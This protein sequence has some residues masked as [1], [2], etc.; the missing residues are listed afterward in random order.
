M[1]KGIWDWQLVTVILTV[2]SL[3]FGGFILLEG[4]T[5]EG[6]RLIIRWS[7]RFSVCCF[8]LAFGGGAMH[9]RIQNSFSFWIFRNRKFFGISF[10]LLHLSHLVALFV[11]Q[12]AFHPIFQIAATINLLVGFGAYCFLI[13]MLLTSFDRFKK[14][15]SHKQWKRLHTIGGYWIFG[16][17]FSSYFKAVLRGEYYD[18]I[19]LSI[20]LIVLGLRIWKMM[21]DRKN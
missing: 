9:K 21:I 4:F 5:E 6:I 18:F 17:F 14:Q 7:A 20:L 12:A 19:F 13:L 15:L 16:V 8:A 11:L 10:A 1:S 3:L 2:A